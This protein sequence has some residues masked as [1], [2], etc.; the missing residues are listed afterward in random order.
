MGVYENLLPGKENALTPEYLTVKCHFSSVR[1]LQKQI[2]A[3][4]KAGKVILSNTTPPGGYYLPQ[5]ETQ[6]KSESLFVHLRI[7]ERIL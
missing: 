4:R 6:W 1:M 7:E 2:E 3:E 5:Q